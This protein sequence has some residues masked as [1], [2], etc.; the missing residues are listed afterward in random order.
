MSS[1]CC[2]CVHCLLRLCPVLPPWV[3]FF[4][5]RSSF[6][7][8]SSFSVAA[9][10]RACA[11]FV[12]VPF[13]VWLPCIAHWYFHKKSYVV[14]CLS[15]KQFFDLFWIRDHAM[16]E[17][18]LLYFIIVTNFLIFSSF[19]SLFGPYTSLHMP[20]VYAQTVCCVV[21]NPSILR[22]IVLRTH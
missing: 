11:L 9:I 22:F 1:V 19:S 5:H 4:P 15:K 8:R 10:I 14:N 16:G 18:N 20:A 12:L 6:W 3:P 7:C 17:L 2:G 13:P 21:F